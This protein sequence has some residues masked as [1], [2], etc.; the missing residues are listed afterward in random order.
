MIITNSTLDELLSQLDP[1][2]VNLIFIGEKSS[3]DISGLIKVTNEKDI[4][5]AG[6]I[7]PQVLHECQAFDDAIVLKHLD[8]NNKPYLIQNIHKR[9]DLAIEPLKEDSKACLVLTDGLSSGIH[10][11]LE[12]MYENY[13]NKVSYIGGGCGSISLK[14][15]PCVFTNEGFVQDSTVVLQLENKI[16][17]GVK[18]GWEKISGPYVANKTDKNR[19]I[20]LNWRPAFDV[21]REIVE[22]N[23]N[24]SFDEHEFFDIAKGFPFGIYKE[25][26]EDLVRD[27]IMVDDEGALVCVGQIGKNASLNILKGAKENLL[28]SA[29]TAANISFADDNFNDVLIV[30]CISRM[31]YLEDDFNQELD[32]IQQR[33]HQ[34]ANNVSLEGVLSLGEI[35]SN[36]EGYLEFYNKTI[37][38]SSIY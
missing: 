13:W 27:P 25:G 1:D 34:S 7:F 19:I 32:K 18:H 23:S 17:L 5:I 3:I 29:E 37:V 35:A 9:D 15:S 33:L 38:V 14:Q 21:Y 10:N 24:M 28:S 4:S 8:T 31:L 16:N 20:E 26:H 12:R 2:K 36:H 6:G 30:D 11:L 22:A